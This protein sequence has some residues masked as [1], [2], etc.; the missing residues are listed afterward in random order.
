MEELKT[1][2]IL[3]KT[4]TI[5][6]LHIPNVPVPFSMFDNSKFTVFKDNSTRLGGYSSGAVKVSSQGSE[7][8]LYV[9][10]VSTTGTSE[11]LLVHSL[12]RVEFAVK[13]I[14]STILAADFRFR[15]LVPLSFVLRLR[16][17]L[18]DLFVLRIFLVVGSS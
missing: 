10:N 17:F 2:F 1:N 13:L 9:S 3:I 14:S 6:I 18:S 7:I 15:D 5:R 11:T 8:L 16:D 4:K 12:D